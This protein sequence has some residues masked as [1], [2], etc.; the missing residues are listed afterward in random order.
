MDFNLKICLEALQNNL[1]PLKKNY[2]PIDYQV[3]FGNHMW[4]K[5]T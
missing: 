4:Y 2:K 1:E 5:Q 3:E